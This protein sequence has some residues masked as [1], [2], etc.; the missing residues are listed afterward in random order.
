MLRYGAYILFKFQ[1]LSI[2]KHLPTSFVLIF[3]N[4]TFFNMSKNLDAIPSVSFIII[5]PVNPS[6]TMTTL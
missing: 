5:F 4:I 3:S 1:S 6:Q 2:H